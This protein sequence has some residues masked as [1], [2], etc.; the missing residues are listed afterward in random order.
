[1][2]K[3][4][5]VVIFL[6]LASSAYAADP[7]VTITAPTTA[8]TY[9][10]YSAP[11]TIEG[12][13]TDDGSV[14][15]VTWT[16]DNCS[17]Y[18]GGAGTAII[19]ST[20]Y[21]R[22]W[23]TMDETACEIVVTATDDEK[24]TGNDTITITYTDTAETTTYYVDPTSTAGS[25]D[26]SAS[27][28]WL[29]L[30]QTT[31]WNVINGELASKHVIVYM[32][33]RLAGSD[34]DE[35][36]AVAVKLL[37]TDM[38]THTLDICANCK[39]NDN[40]AVPNWQ[41]Y[42]GTS[43]FHVTNTYPMTTTN[44]ALVKVNYTTIRGFRITST[45][46]QIFYFWGGD[47]SYIKDNI[48]TQVNGLNG[49]GMGLIYA[50]KR[51]DDEEPCVPQSDHNCGCVN[52]HIEANQIS[53]NYGE[54]IYIGGVNEWEVGTTDPYVIN[55]PGHLDV[56][57]E[58]N[59][60]TNPGYWGGEGDC[61]DV[62]NAVVNV[63]VSGNTLS[64]CP[65]HGIS[66]Q[67]GGTFE[68]N[69]INDVGIGGMIFGTT[70]ASYPNRPGTIVRNNVIV[71]AG[72]A[73]GKSWA[74]GMRVTATIIDA[75]NAIGD[76][77]TDMEIYG[78]TIYATELKPGDAAGTGL[79][80]EQ[81]YDYGLNM[82][83]RNNVF[84]ESEGYEIEIEDA[85][86]IA[87]HS[88]NAFYDSSSIQIKLGDTT[89]TGAE[90]TS[91]WEATAVLSSPSLLDITPPYTAA[92]FGPAYGSPLIDAGYSVI[93]PGY[94][95]NGTLR[96]DGS[97]DI[98]AFEYIGTS[99]V[100][101]ITTPTG[102]STYD[103]GTEDDISIGGTCTDDVG[104]ESVT[105][106]CTNSPTPDSGT[107]SGTSAWTQSF[108]LQAGDT[109]CTFTGTDADTN[110]GQDIITVTYTLPPPPPP[111]G[112]GGATSIHFRGQSQ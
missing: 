56:Y 29:R 106:S 92:N 65:S 8:A 41:D 108:V 46:G 101:V 57:V 22:F 1:M 81:A 52:F 70:W 82:T 59:T 62:K 34:A 5:A 77:W 51:E 10:S 111:P 19:P 30:D 107:A 23:V 7:V 109:A 63:H 6:F 33:A 3:L 43:R 53:N 21:F 26:G 84:L 90:I 13:A 50:R 88:N 9:T 79:H 80:V 69:F 102:S 86:D 100:V 45:Q 36:S 89:Y 58:D 99:P 97:W 54:G 72:G 112:D 96:P 24:N 37:R 44:S 11:I 32:S 49:P 105:Y 18:P 104:C 55:L 87:T 94:D 20:G 12:T 14:S 95:Y 83:L 60:V 38:S 73:V 25:E 48:G 98:G 76:N 15:S 31:Q 16:C 39:Y 75:P 47:H 42:S 64:S 67:S 93:N 110:T 40:D 91:N 85:A 78:N 68:N 66:T 28:P 103:N 4:L 61:I 2:K 74:H 17:A 27:N 35:T 71:K